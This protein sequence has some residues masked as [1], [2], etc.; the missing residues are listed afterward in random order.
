MDRWI[1]TAVGVML[2]VLVFALALRPLGG[3]LRRRESRRAL[4]EFR[5]RREMLEAKFFDVASGL[6]KPRGLRWTGCDWQE[7]VTFG[8]DLRTGQLAAFVAVEISFEAIEGGDM[9][10]VEAVGTLRDAT[11]VFH[12][13]GV[14]WGTGGKALFNMNPADAIRRLE[15]QFEPVKLPE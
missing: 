10:D 14:S 9:E 13:N 4:Q 15:G 7:A 2:L 1:A 3:W 8:R 11:A 12:Y 5:L 6:G